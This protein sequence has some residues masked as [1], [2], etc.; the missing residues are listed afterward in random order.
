MARA[1][2]KGHVGALVTVAKFRM[3]G[4]WTLQA[5]RLAKKV[6]SSCIFCQYLDKLPIKQ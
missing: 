2:R 1:H 6:R 5:G 3:T 4:F